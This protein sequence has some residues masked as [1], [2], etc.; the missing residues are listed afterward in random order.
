MIIPL[1]SEEKLTEKEV[2]LLQAVNYAHYTSAFRDNASSQAV[3]TS[4][5][6]SGDYTKAV[7]AGLSM[8]GGSHA[9]VIDAYYVVQSPLEKIAGVVDA[10]GKVPGWG[11]S[12]YRGEPDPIWQETR[13]WFKENDPKFMGHVDSIT[14]L[15]H[16]KGKKIY[17]N[18]AAYTG[19]AGLVLG[20]PVSILPYLVVGSRLAA[21]TE[22][23]LIE[24]NGARA[25]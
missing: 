25:D 17:P 15:L 23:A 3:R 21:W 7:V 12:F 1:W 18:A 8:L 13:K 20:V 22:L 19:M 14:K 10:G 5:L 9:P 24:A 11:N 4:M 2:Q 6:A 16:A